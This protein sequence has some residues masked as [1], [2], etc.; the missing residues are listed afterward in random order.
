MTA[1]LVIRV[2]AAG[3]LAGGIWPA[4]AQA[5]AKAT[6]A[7]GCVWCGEADF[8]K[9]TGGV[10]TTGGDIG[11]GVGKGGSDAVERGHGG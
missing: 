9:V 3:M 6:F 2:L 10:G 5:P 4:T 11:G 8:D 1:G 7:G